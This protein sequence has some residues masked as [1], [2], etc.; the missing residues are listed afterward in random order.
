ME[1]NKKFALPFACL[2]L[3]FLGAP[4]GVRNRRSGRH[5]GFALSLAV[6]ILY[7]MIVTFA[8]GMGESGQVNPWVAAWSP[9][10]LLALI[11]GLLVRAVGRGGAI[12]V[13]GMFLKSVSLRTGNPS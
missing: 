4:L 1:L 10:I 5:G 8:E 11:A 3:A 6:V 13:P 7:Y 2:L 12:D 9:N